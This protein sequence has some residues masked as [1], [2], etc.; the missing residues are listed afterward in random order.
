M[1]IKRTEKELE[2]LAEDV[3]K[4]WKPDMNANENQSSSVPMKE[5]H[6]CICG[7]Q[8]VEPK[9]SCSVHGIPPSSKEQEGESFIPWNHPLRLE[10]EEMVSKWNDYA[11][12]HLPSDNKRELVSMFLLF[13]SRNR[14]TPSQD[15]QLSKALQELEDFKKDL[16]IMTHNFLTEKERSSKLESRIAELESEMGELPEDCSIKQLRCYYEESKERVR[17]L[18]AVLMA[19]NSKFVKIVRDSFETPTNPFPELKF[20]EHIDA[21]EV[22][23]PPSLPEED[24]VKKLVEAFNK[25]ADT[26]EKNEGEVGAI[27]AHE[28]R[29]LLRSLNLNS[30]EGK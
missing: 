20:K 8:A 1:N 12:T 22:L 3:K 15:A 16:H 29:T 27:V 9:D 30:K 11:Q 14:R 6:G 5:K 17:E 24:K 4:L 26:W 2:A 13:L 21:Q 23:D 28:I 7:S 19:L 10:A 25:R 18:E